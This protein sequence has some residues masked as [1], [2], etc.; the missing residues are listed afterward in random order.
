M[1]IEDGKP[2]GQEVHVP[3]PIKV[4]EGDAAIKIL[5]PGAIAV[6]VPAL[7]V[8][9]AVAQDVPVLVSEPPLGST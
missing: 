2:V 8:F 7:I 3:V 6:D 1:L 5:S 9:Q 4:G